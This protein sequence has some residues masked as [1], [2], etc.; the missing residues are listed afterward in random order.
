MRERL[1]AMIAWPLAA[2]RL[3]GGLFGLRDVFLFGGL[4]SLAH[5]VAQVYAPAAWMVVGLVLMLLAFRQRGP[6]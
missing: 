2:L 5:G 4:A 3:L 1:K 6:E